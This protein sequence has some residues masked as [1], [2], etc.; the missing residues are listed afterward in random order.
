MI[1]LK[2]GQDYDLSAGA[3][4]LTQVRVGLGW[5]TGSRTSRHADAEH[6]GGSH[7]DADVGATDTIDFSLEWSDSEAGSGAGDRD[8]V[9]DLD[10]S[11][12]MLGA[13]DKLP[14]DEFFLFYNN[15][16]SPDGAVV[17]QG[18]NRTGAGEGDDESILISLPRVDP[19]VRRIVIVAT[20]HEAQQHG[21]SFADV[22]NAYIRLV[23]HLSGTEVLRYALNE[24]F[25]D[26]T[27]VVF[28]ELRKDGRT[29]SFKAVGLG[30]RDDLQAF[31]DRYA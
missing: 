27:G 15:L 18:D 24:T 20:I 23:D 26:E 8:A 21:Q 9:C 17:H 19:V 29:W 10:V 16:R 14:R 2:K 11:L 28:G 5:D 4:N 6:S 31:V 7:F 30:S 22:N 13:D 12:F 3:P 1:N 25:S